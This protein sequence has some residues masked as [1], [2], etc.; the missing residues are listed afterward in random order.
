[1]ADNLD[2]IRAGLTPRFHVERELGAGGM[3]TVYLAEDMKHQRPVAIKV[4]K[5]GLAATIGAERFLREIRIAARLI[6]PHILGLH[7]SGEADGFLYYVMPFVDGQSLGQR[8]REEGALPIPEAV[9]YLRD[10]AD[11]MTY[12]HQQGVVHRDIKPQNVML[13]GRHALVMDFGVAKALVAGQ[14]DGQSTLTGSGLALG[15]PAYMAP[16]QAAGGTVDNRADIYAWGVL[17]YEALTGSLPFVRDTLQAVMGAH[18]SAV[19]PSLAGQRPGLAPALEQIVMRCLEKAPDSRYQSSE[20]LLRALDALP[21]S[22][23]RP[24]AVRRRFPVGVRLTGAAAVVLVSAGAVFAWR[25]FKRERWVRAEAVPQV[26]RLLEVGQTD[27]AYSLAARALA[28]LPGDSTLLA[29][30]D[31]FTDPWLFCTQPAGA[32]VFRAPFKDTAHWQLLGSTPTD[33]IRLPA[34]ATRLRFEKAG[35]R[36]RHLLAFAYPPYVGVYPDSAYLDQ[37]MGFNGS[38]W[39][40]N[41]TVVLDRADVPDPG[42]IQVA[43][44]IQGLEF[45]NLYRDHGYPGIDLKAFRIGRHEVTNREYR[46]FV[47]AGGYADQRYW[48]HP[49]NRGGKLLSWEGGIRLLV[50]QTGR[51]GPAT[52]EG[53]DPAQGT[54]DL[55]VGGLSWYEA[56]SYAR[57]AG[58]S[59]PTIYHW[60][61]AAG[62]SI[63]G[64][65]YTVAGSNIESPGPRPPSNSSGMSPS[66]TFDMAGNVRE[67][68]VN[69]DSEGNRYILGGAWSDPPF[70]YS[71]AITLDRFDRSAMNGVRVA[72][73]PQDDPNVALA[74]KAI[75]KPVT[76]D[77]R[78]DRPVGDEQYR[79]FPSMYDYDPTPLNAVVSA[80]DTTPEDW[81]R[82]KV[83]FDAAY[84]GEKLAAYLF[85][86]KR[87]R[88]PFQTIVYFPGAYAATE[89]TSAHLNTTDIGFMIR[90]GRAVLWPIYKSTFERGDTLTSAYPNESVLYRDHVLM[91]AKDLR[92]SIDYVVTRPEIDSSRVAYFGISW[93]GTIGPIFLAIERRL[94]VGVFYIAGLWPIRTRPEVEPLN[95]LPRVTAPVLLI[96]GSND[97]Y[98]PVE[99]SQKPMFAHL[100][101]RPGNKRHVIADGAHFA[102]RAVLIVETLAWFDRFL[103]PVVGPRE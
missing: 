32:H 7:D 33:T 58:R 4:L 27:S 59:L 66:G 48:E 60:S 85:L 95:F 9:K 17:A 82:E 63:L 37:S 21:D 26:Q 57:F 8:I 30:W 97:P 51:P 83:T 87:Y 69:A 55:P 43:G 93:G 39:C 44:G 68:A 74:G 40:G 15:T 5:P 11:A 41:A 18:V 47:R 50:D 64:W 22:G 25:S 84:R 75:P 102:P 2:R 77:P 54:E 94:R 45:S 78:L 99:P 101:T 88:G 6:H 35:Y 76:R 80:R 10:I 96:G 61:A 49:F 3:A 12:A 79:G 73:I 100:G 70:V 46:A 24:A 52:W 53:G 29:I 71:E 1:M 103:G 91:W 42:M 34:G 65:L 23:A 14:A 90:S 36:P 86:P 31:R 67:W 72:D 16:E 56:A 62:I 28:E 20:D 38:N 81:V 98:F 19:P 13:S 89:R 92:R